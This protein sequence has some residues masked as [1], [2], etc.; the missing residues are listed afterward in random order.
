MG[1]ES[2]KRERF[3]LKRQTHVPAGMLFQRIEKIKNKL[4]NGF[5]GVF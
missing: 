3:D 4:E 2:R 5:V 1:L